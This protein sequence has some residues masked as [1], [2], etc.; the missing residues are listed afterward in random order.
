MSA[1]HYSF[2][3][4]LH[5]LRWS[6]TDWSGA[7]S[8][9]FR[10]TLCFSFCCLRSLL[11]RKSLSTFRCS[12]LVNV[13]MSN[14]MDTLNFRSLHFSVLS[15]SNWSWA[16]PSSRRWSS[17][18][19]T[20]CR[21]LSLLLKL[22]LLL[23]LLIHLHHLLFLS[24]VN[25]KVHHFLTI[26]FVLLFVSILL[27]VF[28]EFRFIA[29]AHDILLTSVNV[30]FIVV[31]L[32]HHCTVIQV[33]FF[34]FFSLNVIFVILLL[35]EIIDK[36]LIVCQELLDNFLWHW[37]IV[38]VFMVL[39]LKILDEDNFFVVIQIVNINQLVFI[40]FSLTSILILVRLKLLQLFCHLRVDFL[41]ILFVSVLNR[42]TT[43]FPFIMLIL[44]LFLFSFLSSLLFVHLLL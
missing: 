5:S 11:A 13:F 24:I 41:L 29:I 4:W 2:V 34:I 10:S 42:R 27:L 39:F 16:K 35:I 17:W 28:L 40:V 1:S 3:S 25:I 38:W 15:T 21:S 6:R 20:S 43:I 19:L 31:L 37:Q 44:V 7:C 22:S 32:N 26:I 12:K 23:L 18:W 33:L 9:L 14:S 36:I 30:S 8:K